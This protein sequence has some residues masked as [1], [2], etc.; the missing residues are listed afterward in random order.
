LAEISRIGKPGGYFCFSS[1]NLQGIER[2]LNWRNQLSLNPIKTYV[3]LIMLMLLRCLNRAIDFANLSHAAY[4]I[5]Q[6]ESHNFRLKTYYIRPEAQITQL[7]ADFR[8][9]QVYSWKSGLEITS[10]VELRSNVDLWLY[11]LCSIK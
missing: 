4:A 9:V 8:A 3:N 2:E 7:A 11:Y 6:D 10:N 1:H 5:I